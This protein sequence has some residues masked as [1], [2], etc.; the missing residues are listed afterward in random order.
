[1]HD[2]PPTKRI[3]VV[4]GFMNI[5][6]KMDGRGDGEYGKFKLAV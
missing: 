4:K 3:V 5:E 6:M 1:M 2:I